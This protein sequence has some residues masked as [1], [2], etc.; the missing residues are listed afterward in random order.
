M[1]SDVSRASLTLTLSEPE[2]IVN[3]TIT[4]GL[5]DVAGYL[6]VQAHYGSRAAAVLMS[7]DLDFLPM[8][9]RG[10]VSVVV[11]M[12]HAAAR[13][14]CVTGELAVAGELTVEARMRFAVPRARRGH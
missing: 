13:A 8:S 3:P 5:L 6:L 11:R 4:F 9:D 7:S 1:L 10:A 2:Q 14:A 12:Q